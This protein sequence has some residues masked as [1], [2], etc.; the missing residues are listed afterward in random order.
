MPTKKDSPFTD[1]GFESVS[2]SEKLKRVQDLFNDVSGQYDLM[3]D[4]M[5]GGL[6]R[7][8]K[9][10]FV[11][12]VASKSHEHILDLAG[13]TGDI[14]CRLVKAASPSVYVCDLSEGMV[15][16]GKKRALDK[17]FLKEIHWTVGKGE[18][19][20]FPAQSF[21]A[22]TISFGLRNVSDRPQVLAEIYRVLKASGHFYCLEFSKV[23]NACLDN[24]YKAYSFGIIPKIGK[25]VAQDEEAYQYLVESI[26]KFP[27][28]EDLAQ[29]IKEAGF[30]NVT[31]TNL[32]AGIA[33]IHIGRK[34]L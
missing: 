14:A 6:H 5:S 17:G 11:K 26:A 23:Q 7:L 29:E 25:Y 10:C 32:A 12:E 34:S 30:Q 31:H 3:N 2:I 13:G 28:Q 33:A 19:L 24:I 8:W 22:V 9:D 16:K 4:I 15:Q 1:F 27:S 18:A 21:D 20:P